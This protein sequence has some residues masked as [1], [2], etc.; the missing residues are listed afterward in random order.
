MGFFLGLYGLTGLAWG[1]HW[2]KASFFPFF[3]LV[4]CVPVG[5]FAVPLT[6]PLRLLVSRIVEIIAH[7]GLAPDLIRDGTQLFDAATHVCLRGGGGLQRHPQPGGAAGADH[8][9]WL[10]DLQSPW[11]RGV[12][13]LVAAAAG[14]AG[15]RGAAVFHHRRGG[16]VRAECRQSGGDR[17]RLSH[18]CGG[19]WPA[20]FWCR[21]GWKKAEPA[22]WPRDRQTLPIHAMNRLKPSCS[23]MV[24]GAHRRHRRRAGPRQIQPKA[25]PARRENP[26]AARQPESGSAAARDVAR[27]PIP[28]ACRRRRW[29]RTCCRRIPATASG[30]IRRQTVF[31][32]WSMWC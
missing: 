15:Q 2:L 4:F 12:M 3:L 13:M 19:H 7:L 6:L 27:L 5:E 14:G 30:F 20:R 9:L 32:A 22:G 25:G 26:P 8:D 11:K 17:F 10:C 16:D 18:L 1:R 28:G 23:V 29:S 31:S 24:S 21:A